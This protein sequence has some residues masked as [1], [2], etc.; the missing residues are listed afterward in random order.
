[1]EAKYPEIAVCGLSCRLCPAYHRE[2]KSR[3][4][5]CKT[6]Y[7]M[8]AACA[9]LRCAMKKNIEFC[10]LCNE[11]E[12]CPKWTKLREAGKLADSIKCYQ[13]LEDDIAFIEKNG[14]ANF[15]KTQIERES[16]LKELLKGFD[17]G[18]SKSYYCIAATVL[19]TDEL[20]AALK[21]ARAIPEGRDIK[22]KAKSMH[23]ILDETAEKNSYCLKLRKG[24]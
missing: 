20:K 14:L 8:G 7:R 13:T 6:E 9:I 19:T 21:K 3:C 18:R 22:D 23:A 15:R 5:G 24:T 17:E 2:T 1:M 10:G 12:G 16:L 11:H 4:P